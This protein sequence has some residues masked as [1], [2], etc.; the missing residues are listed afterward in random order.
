L[1]NLVERYLPEIN[2]V[3]KDL[4]RMKLKIAFCYPSTYRAGMA[5]LSLQLIYRL[6]NSYEGVACERSFKPLKEITVPYTLESDRPIA[7]MDVIAFTMQY[8]DDFTNILEILHRAGIPLESKERT[9]KDPLIIAGGPSA[10]SNPVPMAPFIDGFMLGDLELVNDQLMEAFL[11]GKN[12]CGRMELLNDFNWFWVPS[13]NNGRKV[14]FA[15]K[16]DIND[17]FYPT[18]QIIPQVEEEDP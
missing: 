2:A 16:G 1:A 13:L 15:P 14:T 10:Q 17:Y 7:T 11:A 8:E 18:K 5:A 12:R 9:E 3:K 4:S 6:W